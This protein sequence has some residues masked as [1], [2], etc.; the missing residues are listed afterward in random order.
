[1]MLLQL[2]APTNARFSTL[3]ASPKKEAKTPTATATL[4]QLQVLSADTFTPSTAIRSGG[5]SGGK[6]VIIPAK[7]RAFKHIPKQQLF[8]LIEEWNKMGTGYFDVNTYFG[9]S[10]L[11]FGA[12]TEKQ[13][14][15]EFLYNIA[16]CL[17]SIH[18]FVKAK[19]SPQKEEKLNAVIADLRDGL[20]SFVISC[21][22][23]PLQ[24]ELE[25]TLPELKEVKPTKSKG[26]SVP[27][28]NS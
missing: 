22:N 19:S 14:G 17:N 10:H 3:M 21:P 28:T 25:K 2:L 13:E 6:W 7:L 24:R 18:R 23:T 26:V 27:S 1:M 11:D 15:R 5:K 8:L 9:V 16:N 4:P 20:D 12:E